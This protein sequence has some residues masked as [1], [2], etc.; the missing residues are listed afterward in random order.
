MY[1]RMFALSDWNFIFLSF[2]TTVQHT[3]QLSAHTFTQEKMNIPP[4]PERLSEFMEAVPPNPDVRHRDGDDTTGPGAK[5]YLETN[6]PGPKRAK[7]SGP[8]MDSDKGAYV[9]GPSATPEAAQKSRKG[10]QNEKNRGRRRG[11]RLP[12]R[13]EADRPRFPRLP[14]KQCAVLIGFS[15]TNYAGMQM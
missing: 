9:S 15:G 11:S 14:K 4:V 10:K 1:L 5:R 7:I 13:D 3:P 8:D 6:P 12:A 2:T